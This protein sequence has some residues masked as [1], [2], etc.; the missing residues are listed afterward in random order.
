MFTAELH[1]D[2]RPRSILPLNQSRRTRSIRQQDPACRRRPEHPF[3][4]GVSSCFCLPEVDWSS[5]IPR[6]QRARPFFQLA[7]IGPGH[8]TQ[9]YFPENSLFRA[10]PDF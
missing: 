6:S 4:I 3:R 9:P 10:E 8:V 5:E 2:H 1:L 7:Q